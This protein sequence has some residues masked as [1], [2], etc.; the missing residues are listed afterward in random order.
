MRITLD[1]I[2]I[3]AGTQLAFAHTSWTIEAGQHWAILGPNGSGKSTL[4]K[5]VSQDLRLAEGSVRY[6]FEPQNSG[7]GRAYLQPNEILT[8]SAETHQSFLRRFAAYHQARWQ[9]FEGEE[10]PTVHQ[11]L[12]SENPGAPQTAASLL[13][14]E[15]LLERQV[16][17]LSHGESRKVFLARLL[18][19]NPRLLILDDPFTGLDAASR[20]RLRAGIAG[21]LRSQHPAVLLVS[22]RADDLPEG[23]S[24]VLL[25][26]D[27]QVTARGPRQVVL[28]QLAHS[29]TLEQTR[30]TA[31]PSPAFERMV[32]AY[33]SRL[34]SSLPSWS[35][36][37]PS[38]ALVQMEKVSV[39][40][41]DTPVLDNL[42]WTVRQGERWALLGPNGAGKTTLLSLILADNP[43]AYRNNIR[44]FGQKRGSGESIWEIKARIGWVSP[45][46]HAFYPRTASSQEVVCSGFYDSVG[47][48]RRCSAEQRAVAAGWADALGVAGLLEKPFHTLSTGEQ[49]LILL[50][51]ALVKFPPLLVLDEP[52]QGLDAQHRTRFTAVVDL[53]CTR[54]PVTL[55]YVSHYADEIPT[56]VTHRLEL[57]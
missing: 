45:E 55:I 17:L 40:Y 6:F 42:D 1:D 56:A 29:P 13:G 26:R 16:H 43:Q 38:P 34:G 2:T 24:H 39:R 15:P 18:V 20:E 5:A 10:A 3:R 22:A 31:M 33:A 23:I 27:H 51:R 47:L 21:L 36:P 30:S 12:A 25:V 41:Q 14:L 48:Y 28:D 50:C 46:L 32:D 52:C 53:I 4:A 7:P 54:A 19:R 9:S 37:G 57:G 8:F 35:P 44:L 11:L 49:R